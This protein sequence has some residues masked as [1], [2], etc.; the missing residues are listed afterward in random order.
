[1]PAGVGEAARVAEGMGSLLMNG[2]MGWTCPA[3][4][5]ERTTKGGAEEEEEEVSWGEGVGRGVVLVAADALKGRAVCP[6]T[7]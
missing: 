6:S 2:A 7:N 5:P 3:S 4:G 1:M